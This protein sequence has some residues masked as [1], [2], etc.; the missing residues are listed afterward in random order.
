MARDPRI[1]AKIEQA[2]DFAKPILRH[3]RELVHGTIDGVEET[4]KWGM[5][6]FTYKGKTIAHMAAFKEHCAMSVAGAERQEGSMGSFGRIAKLS[7]LPPDAELADKL[8]QAR[9]RIEAGGTTVRPR[10]KVS[11]KPVIPVPDDFAAALARDEVAQATFE[12]FPPSQ[13]WE[14][15]DWITGAKREDTRAKRIGEAVGWIAEGKR[16]NWK[17]ER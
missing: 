17:Y 4:I 3:I 6:H 8:R 2:A 5:P 9:A 12:T 10:P 15:L 1:D 16:R 11:Q 7:D 13:R 14:Y